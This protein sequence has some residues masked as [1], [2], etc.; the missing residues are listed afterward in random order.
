MSYQLKIDEIL[1][2]LSLGHAPRYAEF[3][4]KIEALANEAAE[5]LAEFTG[6]V[7]GVGDF[8]GLAWAGL[9]VPFFAA[10]EGQEIPE[11]MEGL[12]DASEW[13]VAEPFRCKGC[14][15][16]EPDCSADPCGDVIADRGEL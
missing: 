1:E 4:T 10:H 6:T 11:C 15:R 5:Y 9:C 12:D 3:R 7:A 8:Q 16:P 2:A 13:C 14:G